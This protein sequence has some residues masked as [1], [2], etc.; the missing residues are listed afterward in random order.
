MPFGIPP[1]P[2]ATTRRPLRER[3]PQIGESERVVLW[4]GSV[5]RWLDAATAIRAVKDLTDVRLV[6]TAGRPPSDNAG[7]LSATDEAR[8]LARRLGLLGDKV[9][10][11]DDWVPYEQRHHY[12]RDADVGITLHGATAEATVAARSRYMD[13]LWSG[14]PC[15][16][17]RGD[18]LAERFARAGFAVLVPP[19][20]PTAVSAALAGMLEDEDALER[21]RAAAPELA[22]KLGWD[23]AASALSAVLETVPSPRPM[24]LATSL[25]V[26]GAVGSE[27]LRLGRDAIAA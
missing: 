8:S 27:Y 13:Y 12:L 23:T 24:T 10:F 18:E 15:V 2:P 14:L 1:A 9:L 5:W 17:A 7:L 21:R 26:L 20:D 19:R 16:L 4:W 6:I 22:A 25:S 11:L 3:F